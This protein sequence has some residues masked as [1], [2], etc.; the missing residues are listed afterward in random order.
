MRAYKSFLAEV[1]IMFN[2]K[3]KNIIKLEQALRDSEGD[4]YIIMEFCDGGDLRKW[5]LDSVGQD[6]LLDED[7]II[8][9]LR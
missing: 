8:E 4:L 1:F 7:L 2:S 9:M 6:D 3:H 5:R